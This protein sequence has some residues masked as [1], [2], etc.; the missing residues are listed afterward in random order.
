M[1]KYF[2]KKLVRDNIPEIIKAN[3][4][5]F[6]LKDIDDKKFEIE[7]KKK[8]LEEARE[9]VSASN[10]NILNE[11]ADVLEVIKTLSTYYKIPFSKVERCRVDKRKK[12]GGFKKKLFL[13]WSNLPAGK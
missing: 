4:G 3:G 11:L 9:L 13:V 7:L 12:R 5:E 2:H 10:E 6:E 1:K 8:L